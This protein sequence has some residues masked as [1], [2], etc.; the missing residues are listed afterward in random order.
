MAQPVG[1]SKASHND[2]TCWQ[3]PPIG[4]LQNGVDSQLGEVTHDR[5]D[6]QWYTG[7]V[8]ALLVSRCKDAVGLALDGAPDVEH[9]AASLLPPVALGGRWTLEWS[10]TPEPR[11]V[12]LG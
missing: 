8:G 11:A 2:V 9:S 6:P 7:F 1:T 12:E 3:L 10:D 5:F 4:G